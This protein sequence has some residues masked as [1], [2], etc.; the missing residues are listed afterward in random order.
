[1]VPLIISRFKDLILC[2]A[3]IPR[4]D[5]RGLFERSRTDKCLEFLKS[6]ANLSQ[7][8]SSNNLL[9]DRFSSSNEF[10]VVRL[11]KA[12]HRSFI[13]AEYSLNHYYYVLLK[14]EQ[15][16]SVDGYQSIFGVIN[17]WQLIIIINPLIRSIWM[18][19]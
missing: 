13:S 8:K 14:W 1:M 10:K 17:T 9:F 18:K 3:S 6:R 5:I 19:N 4:W 12:S 7:T 15:T 11:S 16:W 2:K